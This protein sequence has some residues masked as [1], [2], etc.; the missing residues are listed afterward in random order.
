L[1]TVCAP[2]AA[3]TQQFTATGKA[4]FQHDPVQAHLPDP[5]SACNMTRQA[6]IRVFA[7][8][9]F[10]MILAVLYWV[11][12]KQKAV[13]NHILMCVRMVVGAGII[14]TILADWF[15]KAIQGSNFALSP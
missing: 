7:A 1:T 8:R 12:K 10:L 5:H 6:T 9:C 13:G 3:L 15:P 14:F 2:G 11:G 4:L